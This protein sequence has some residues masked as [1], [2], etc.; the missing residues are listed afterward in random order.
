MTRGPLWLERGELFMFRNLNPMALGMTGRQSELIELALTYG[1]SSL[2]VDMKA[3]VKRARANGIDQA[4]RFIV[5][6]NLRGGEF[7]LPLELTAPETAYRSNLVEFGEFVEIAASLN[8]VACRATVPPVCSGMPYQ[9][10]FELHRTRLA[11]IAEVLA[12]H[13]IPLGLAFLAASSHRQSSE[14]PFIYEG[15]TAM[16]LIR[17]IGSPNVGLALD[18]WNW[19]VG[20][21]S[22]DD[23]FAIPTD[24]IVS[25]RL[26]DIPASAD[27][28][29][30]ADDERY[31][32]GDGG[33]TD[34]RAIVQ[35]L[36]TNQYAGPVTL[37]PTPARFAGMTRDA[38]VRRAKST[39]D[40]LF[41]PYPPEPPAT[42]E[43][44][45]PS[46]ADAV[47]E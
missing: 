34:C 1:F 46:E 9:E 36:L 32:P 16:T 14:S 18:T 7:A 25:V 24:R 40:N 11:E 23:L 17:T 37:Y 28:N 39:L 4:R 41:T 44:S 10:T 42:E 35:H 2:D 26:A 43:V 5:S 22:L 45:E 19:F 8:A 6:A 30:I 12:R 15:E 20:G 21:G 27:L 3:I 31:M 29:T 33:L 47:S 13:D 38:I